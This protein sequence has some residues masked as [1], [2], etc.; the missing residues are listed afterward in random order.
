MTLPPSWAATNCRQRKED[1]EGKRRMEK[2]KRI[3]G[4]RGR[5]RKEDKG[6]RREEGEVEDGGGGKRMM[7]EGRWQRVRASGGGGSRVRERS[8]TRGRKLGFFTRLIDD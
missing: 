5:G 4:W 7:E 1:G 6:G 2:N 8:G 3:G